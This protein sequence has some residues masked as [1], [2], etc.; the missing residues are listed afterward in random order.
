MSEAAR[1][2]VVVAYPWDADDEPLAP[3]RERCPTLEIV[4]APYFGEFAHHVPGGSDEPDRRRA[5]RVGAC[6]SRPRPRLPGRIGELAPDLRWVQAIGAGVDHLD[7]C[8]LPGDCVVTNAA[9]VA[10]APIA[11]VR[12]RPFA[13]G[14]EAVRRDRRAAVGARMEAEVRHPGG[15]THHRS[16]RSRRDRLRGRGTRARVRHARHRNAAQLPAGP[17]ARRSRRATRDRRPSRGARTLRRRRRER[18]GHPRDREPVRR[19]RVRG[20]ETR[21]LV[22]QRRP[23]LVGRRS[24]SHRRARIGPRGRRRAR[25]HPPG[26]DT[27]RRSPVVGAQHLDLAPLL[28][29]TGALHRQAAR[30]CSPTTSTATPR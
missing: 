28:D 4:A 19:C 17:T 7:A 9:G 10:A 29:L 1:T 23:R 14:V 20:D 21:R 5:R 3:L 11:E 8:G 6:R 16:D 30:R 25:R 18:A 24:R 2:T 13:R 26:A 27:R 12:D 22:L 15:G